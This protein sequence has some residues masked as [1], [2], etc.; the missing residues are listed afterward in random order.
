M[1][2]KIKLNKHIIILFILIIISFLVRV[3][4]IEKP[5]Y[6]VDEPLIVT[7]G[8]KYYL[9]SDYNPSLY[10]NALPGGKLWMGLF[11]KIFSNKDV[12]SLAQYGIRAF[13][14]T[15]L[16]S[17][18]LSGLEV[19]ARMPGA[20]FG[21][22]AGIFIYLLIKE[23]YG[24]NAALIGF[25]LFAFNPLIITYSRFAVNE[26]YQI[27]YMIMSIYFF[28]KS[29]FTKKPYFLILSGL[30]LGLSISTKL[31]G[32]LILP[33]FILLI[34][35]KNTKFKKKIIF[36]YKNII[37]KSLII[38]GLSLFVLWVIVGFDLETILT[39]VNYYNSEGYNGFGIYLFNILKDM[40]FYTNPL[41]WVMLI[42][43]LYK[44]IKNKE[45]H[46]F[47]TQFVLILFSVFLFSTF[48]KTQSSIKR[49]I[50]FTLFIFIVSSRMFENVK[51]KKIYLIPIIIFLVDFGLIMYYFPNTAL[52]T[53]ITCL[54]QN[55]IENNAI[56][57]YDSR[58][59]GEK[60]NELP[61]GLL[62]ETTNLE[63][64]TRHYINNT[65]YY[66]SS[67]L[68]S[69]LHGITNPSFEFLK[70]NNFSYVVK[71]PYNIE[72]F[73]ILGLDYRNC[74]YYPV[75]V[76]NIEISRIYNLSSC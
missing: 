67:S 20:I 33:F 18:V 68:L 54:S 2:N 50:Q 9:P 60:I 6:V 8:I 10:D 31:N 76:K 17:E 48:F 71:N 44:I 37:I 51:D 21:F 66:L 12:S 55:C 13:G 52:A 75:N 15:T 74:K 57:Y 36:N 23:I 11:I 43:S 38:I 26:I 73:E 4:E 5:G 25:I 32:L 35:L 7:G 39:I 40:F 27:S 30:F 53:S 19:Y 16:N 24:K 47:K 65:Q 69:W 56:F 46:N 22:I 61:L 28:Y 14:M 1:L 34:I 42:Y 29:F 64:H 41:V 3:L 62:Y 58:A 49:A 59:V 45:Y 70:Q 63:G 72:G